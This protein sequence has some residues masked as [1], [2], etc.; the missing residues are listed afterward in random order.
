MVSYKKAAEHERLVGGGEFGEGHEEGGGEGEGV[1]EEEAGFSVRGEGELR[2]FLIGVKGGS[3]F[4]TFV[5]KGFL[6]LGIGLGM[7]S[8]RFWV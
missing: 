1:V 6:G 8:L 7:S 2:G 3:M 5:P 4:R